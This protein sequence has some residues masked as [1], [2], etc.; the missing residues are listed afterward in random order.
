MAYKTLVTDPSPLARQVAKF[1]QEMAQHK[2]DFALAMLVPSETGLSDKWNLV[3]SAPWIDRDGL[4]A[5]IP[6]IT[7]SLL[8]HLKGA[9]PHKLERISVLPTTDGLVVTMAGLRISLGK[10]YRVQYLPQAEDATV[11]VAEPAGASRVYQS[12]P[13]QTRA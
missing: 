11:L 5:T 7:T 4:S 10:V 9:N 8:K 13:V 3:L 12:Q 6:T 2:G 1:L